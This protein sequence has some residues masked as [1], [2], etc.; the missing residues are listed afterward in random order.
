MA[1]NKNFFD[2]LDGDWR[3]AIS[4]TYKDTYIFKAASSVN[5]KGEIIISDHRYEDNE[6]IKGKLIIPE[7]VTKIG[8]SA[9][10]GCTGITEIEFPSTL[11]EIDHFAFSYCTGLTKIKFNDGL[12]VI[13]NNAFDYCKNLT[14]VIFPSSI[15]RFGYCSF[16]GCNLTGDLILPKPNSLAIIDEQA[17]RNNL[18]LSGRLVIPAGF[19]EI[20]EY[21]F[22][23]CNFHGEIR[24]PISVESIGERA[25]LGCKF[26]KI[27]MSVYTECHKEWDS[28][29]NAAVEKY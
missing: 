22:A 29:C 18:N 14:E 9:F 21:A 16:S 20:G 3:D 28:G 17:F 5:N 1:Y 8:L 10:S 15:K 6:N 23:D 26:M 27:Y 4:D 7:G 25:F 24:I 13:D 19:T 2:E 11:K 12:E